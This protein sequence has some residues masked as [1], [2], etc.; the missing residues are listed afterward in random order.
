MSFGGVSRF[1]HLHAPVGCR[2]VLAVR[3]RGPVR[4]Q[5]FAPF[6]CWIFRRPLAERVGRLRGDCPGSPPGSI[7][8]W[9]TMRRGA[10]LAFCIFLGAGPGCRTEVPGTSDCTIEY[11]QLG[12][13]P[14]NRIDLLVELDAGQVKRLVRDDGEEDSAAIFY[15]FD[16]PGRSARLHELDLDD[17]GSVDATLERTGRIL[18]RI[19]LFQVDA[20][21]D[22]DQVD[23]LQI[24]I[25]LET[26]GRFGE[27]RPARMVYSVPCGPSHE[28]SATEDGDRV[29]LDIDLNRDGSLD[30][31]MLIRFDGQQVLGWAVDNDRDGFVDFRGLA[32][33]RLDGRVEAVE[34]RNW[35]FDPVA[36]AE[37]D[38]DG[39]GRLVGFEE[40]MDGD[41]VVD[42]RLRYAPS[43]WEE[44]L[45]GLF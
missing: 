17:N 36:L 10:S 19:D 26:G 34:W 3:L 37:F 31:Q 33:Y 4:F 11:L 29:T 32:L 25:P 40:D 21:I 16:A 41:G 2:T 6:R 13:A 12:A 42:N 22:D 15:R 35:E 9:S 14:S 38:Y 7:P 44:T 23:S 8:G 43:C 30:S 1:G 28:I 18:D 24:S 45:D 5:T 20:V 39:E 27:W